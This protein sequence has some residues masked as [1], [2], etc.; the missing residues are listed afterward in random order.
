MTSALLAIGIASALLG[1]DQAPGSVAPANANAEIQQLFARWAKAFEAKDVNGVMAMY[2]PGRTFTAY[3]I[4]PPL[5]FKGADAYRRDYAD[6]FALF[7]GPLH[8]EL[9]DDHIEAGNDVAI[10]YGLERLTGKT[11]AGA[12][13]DMW[14]RYTEG[15]KKIDGQWRVVHEQISVPADMETGKA[16]LDLKP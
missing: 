12:P 11:K 1:A 10:A 5:Q 6:F 14:L 16:K 3:D 7:E 13:V 8:V 15:L 2:A 4:V 9:R